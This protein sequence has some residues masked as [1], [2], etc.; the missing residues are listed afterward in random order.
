MKRAIVCGGAG[1]VGSALVKELV[2]NGVEVCV[3][4]RPGFSK[5]ANESAQGLSYSLEQITNHAID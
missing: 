4:V 5:K 3:I 2:S 1:F